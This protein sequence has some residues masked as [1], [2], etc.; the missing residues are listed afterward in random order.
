MTALRDLMTGLLVDSFSLDEIAGRVVE[1]L[2]DE[3]QEGSWR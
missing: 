2:E 3:R 1:A